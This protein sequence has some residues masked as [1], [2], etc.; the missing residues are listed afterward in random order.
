MKVFAL[1]NRK[2]AALANR[3][4]ANDA[5]FYAEVQRDFGE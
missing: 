4:L 2:A 1:E 5:G 3:R